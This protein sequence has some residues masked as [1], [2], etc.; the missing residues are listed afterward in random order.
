MC[1]ASAINR[2]LSDVL[3]TLKY[4]KHFKKG[5]EF[6]NSTLLL[7]YILEKLWSAEFYS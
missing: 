3:N 7:I 1:N 2:L 5:I 4:F 6:V